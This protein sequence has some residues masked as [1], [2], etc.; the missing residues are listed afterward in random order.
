MISEEDLTK[1]QSIPYEERISRIEKLL[2][3]KEKPRAFELGLLLALKM[4]QEIREKKPL[5]STTAKMVAE[6]NRTYPSSL[7]EEAI[8]SA[9]EFLTNPAKLAEKIKAGMKKID[10]KRDDA[11]KSD[12]TES[13][14]LSEGENG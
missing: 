9:K 11:D 7:V 14:D 4:G 13:K 6:W 3:G 5:G 2:E 8:A 12:E 1:Q 10:E